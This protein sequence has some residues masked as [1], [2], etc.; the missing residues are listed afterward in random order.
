[1]SETIVNPLLSQPRIVNFSSIGLSGDR[2]IPVSG[3]D[4]AA[5]VATI[6]KYSDVPHVYVVGQK[7]L[8]LVSEVLA[9]LESIRSTSYPHA[10]FVVD[11]DFSAF[12]NPFLD[13]VPVDSPKADD[14]L[15]QADRY[16][17]QR[18][19]FDKDEL[20]NKNSRE[21]PERV[22]VMII[23]AGITG[24]YAAHRL[25]REGISF[26]VVE[27]RDIAGGIWSKYANATS[28]V[29]TSEGAYRLRDKKIRMNR[30][31]STTVEILRDLHQLLSEVS[32]HLY[33][34]TRAERIDGRAG[35]YRVTAVRDGKPRTVACKGIILAVNDR[36]GSPRTVTW[37]NQHLFK[38]TVS[39]GISNQAL[40]VQWRGKKVVVVG[41]GAFAVE[42]C[43]TALENGADSVTVVCRRHGTV[44]PKIIDYLNFATPYDENFQHDRKS[45]IRNM[46]LWKKLYD[47][48]GATQPECWMGKIKHEGHTIS[49]SDIWFI[50]HFLNKLSTVFGSVTGLYEQG[51]IVNHDRRVEADVVINCIGF[52]RNAPVV[53]KMCD[54]NEMYN[55]N[56]IDKDLMY[57]A[58]AYI[59]DDVFNSFFGSSVLE[60]TKFYMDVFIDFFDSPEFETMIQTDGIEKISIDD[61]RWSHYI[62]GAEALIKR[63]PR[64]YDAARR[65]IDERTDNFL[66]MHDLKTYVAANRREW[67]D[68]HRMLSGRP[69]REDECLPYVFD[70]LVEKKI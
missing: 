57:L 36:I 14:I 67:F 10:L 50:A 61:R 1:M 40:D 49:V 29:N 17:R 54:Y 26:C 39:A 34:R 18:F 65:Q 60:M 42:N 30:D 70:K 55:N 68:L 38:G 7:W 46:M 33:T 27:E 8:K 48:S 3:D 31:H 19:S 59:D 63:F 62:A 13:I 22:D 11:G 20:D 52:H 24:L 56:Y 51:V 5:V 16:G 15:K 44:C 12:A 6:R 47:L 2:V 32:D 9:S 4:S 23:G 41:M 66:E 69:M 43:R 28:Q 21:L 53:R 35:Q 25:A 37:E 45:N 58:D 64:F